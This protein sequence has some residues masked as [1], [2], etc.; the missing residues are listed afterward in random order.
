[1]DKN[2]YAILKFLKKMYVPKHPLSVPELICPFLPF[3]IV[4]AKWRISES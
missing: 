4:S 1:M 2:D 3:W